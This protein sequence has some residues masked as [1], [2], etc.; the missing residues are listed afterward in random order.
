[1][2]D[3]TLEP[4]V[5]YHRGEPR[6][7]ASNPIGPM[8]RNSGLNVSVSKHEFSDLVGQIE[9][10]IKFLICNAQEMRRLRDFPG[11]EGM[12]LDFPVEDRDVAV[13]RDRFPPELMAL[14]GELRIGLAV[15]HYPPPDR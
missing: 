4:L 15:S 3:S 9:D 6:A 14:L 11:L 13:Q 8:H 10:A 12:E 5:V 2:R 7:P 1:M